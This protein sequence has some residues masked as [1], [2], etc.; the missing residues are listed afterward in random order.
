MVVR[1][2]LEQALTLENFRV[3]P[4]AN[5]KEA[6]REFDANPVDIVLLDLNLGRESGWDTIHE[7]RRIRPMLPVIVMTGYPGQDKPVNPILIQAFMEKPLDLQKLID[8][9]KEL[10][11]AQKEPNGTS[12]AQ[13]RAE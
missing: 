4:A 8:K 7:L 1:Q 9:L 13:A 6:L 2:S 3:F 10:A 5:G 11:S 12:F